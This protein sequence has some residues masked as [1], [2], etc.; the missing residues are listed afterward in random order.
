[1]LCESLQSE[2]MQTPPIDQVQWSDSRDS[3]NCEFR[4]S[5]PWTRCDSTLDIVFNQGETVS[6]AVLSIEPLRRMGP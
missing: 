4:Q 5:R 1:M 3:I 2:R 6:P